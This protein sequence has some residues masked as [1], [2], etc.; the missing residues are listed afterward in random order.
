M[1]DKN[2]IKVVTE[3]KFLGVVFDRTL[4]YTNYVD[5]PKTNC[6]GALD[7]LKEFGHIDWAQ[8]E[9]PYSTS[10]EP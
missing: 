4:L 1:L 3:A 10:T 8:I 7:I 2:S 6:L 5:Y 9:K